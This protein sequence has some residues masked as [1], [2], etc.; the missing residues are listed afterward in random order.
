MKNKILMVL[1]ILLALVGCNCNRKSINNFGKDKAFLQKHTDAVVLT[2]ADGSSQVMVVPEYQ[3]RV[4]T[5]TATGDSGISFGWINYDLI[6]SGKLVKHM[7]AFGGEDRFW[8]G[9]EGGQFGLYFP[10]QA[11]F[12]LDNWQVPA[13]FDT[14]NYPI[15][16]RTKTSVTFTKQFSLV[17]YSSIKFNVK[18]TRK[19]K[20]LTHRKIERILGVKIPRQIKMVGYETNNKVTNVG[21]KGWNKQ[22]GLLSIWI[23]GNYTPSKG[24]KIMLPIQSG[25]EEKLGKKVDIYASFGAIPANRLIVKDNAIIFTA[26]GKSRGKIGLTPQRAKDIVGSYDSTKNVLTIIKYNKPKDAKEYVNSLWEIQKQPFQGD[27]V[28]AYNDGP[29]G[30]GLKPLGPFYEIETSSPALAL[31]PNQ[32]YSHIRYTFHFIASKKDLNV[33]ATQLLG[34]PLP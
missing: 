14:D 16:S 8:M 33:L 34:V 24:A 19:V 21:T 28:N 20:L 26:D 3:G 7:N 4:M 29:L 30:K 5:S 11:D 17:N 22:T 15:T 27:V 2:S 10:P 6:K 9:P 23:L 1:C 13:P 32:S 25:S 18:V 12:N 31:K